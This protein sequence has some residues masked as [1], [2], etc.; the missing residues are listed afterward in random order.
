MK[1]RIVFHSILVT[2]LVLIVVA[3]SAPATTAPQ[4]TAAPAQ[5]TAA[6]AQPTAAPAQ[7]TAAPAQ[8]TAAPAQPTAATEAT[9]APEATV[10]PTAT[11]LPTAQAGR[12]QVR[13]FIGLGTGNDPE[14]VTVEQAIADKFNA[15][16]DKIQLILEVVAYDASRDTLATE[17]ASGNPP[18]IVGP[19]GVSGAEAFHGQWLDLA[20]LIAKNKYDLT[21]FDKG[22]VDFYKVGGEGQVGLPFAIYPSAVFYQR[23]MFDE[24]DLNYPPHKY[25][26]KYKWKDGTEEEWTY[27]TLNKLALL[28]TVD[29]NNKDAS[30]PAFDV[31]NIVQYGYEPQ[32]QDLRAVGSYWGADTFV[33]ADGKT[34]QI[35]AQWADAW[36]WVYNGIW[37]EHTIATGPVRESQEYGQGNPFN[38]G[39]VAMALT[40]LWY[41]CCISDAGETW[42]VAVVPSYKGKTTSNFN[43]DTFRIL[44]VSKHQE[45]AFTVL[46]YLLGPASL[47]LLKTYGGMPGR[48]ADQQAFFDAQNE[49]FP[50]KVDWQVFIDGIAYADNPSFE[51]YMPNYNESF[52]LANVFLNKLYTTEGLDLDKEIAQFQKDL[53]AVFDKKAAP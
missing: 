47:E 6:P 16:Q 38:S 41:T 24:A 31:K 12:T 30:D 19:V 13:W 52:D 5:P 39:K 3:C 27:E 46:S 26:E 15:S 28:L 10:A 50:Q 7:P 43:A 18:D 44:K 20:P 17:I 2:A 9:T 8:P 40:H 37:K 48:T 1:H 21:Q 4:P 25:G 29:K 49:S 45:E 42:D 23:E 34:A 14:Q 51:G 53:Q 36:K 35:P 11:A 33:A 32:Y 22:A